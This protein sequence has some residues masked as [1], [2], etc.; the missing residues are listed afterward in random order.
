M[1]RQVRSL[2][3]HGHSRYIHG[4]ISAVITYLANVGWDPASLSHW[5]R[6]D[7][8]GLE[9]VAWIFPDSS[10]DQQYVDTAD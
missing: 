10:S 8:Y 2:G 4:P 5:G 3:L 1:F 9:P 6:P 7:E